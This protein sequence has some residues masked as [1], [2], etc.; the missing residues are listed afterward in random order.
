[1]PV[2]SDAETIQIVKKYLDTADF[3]VFEVTNF[4]QTH[5]HVP[6]IFIVYSNGTDLAEGFG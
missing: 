2:L 5:K 6:K 3:D 4:L 1:M